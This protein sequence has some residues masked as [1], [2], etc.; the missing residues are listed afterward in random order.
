MLLRSYGAGAAGSS[1]SGEG[2][3]FPVQYKE[4]RLEDE[5][6]ESVAAGRGGRARKR[7][8]GSETPF[9]TFGGILGGGS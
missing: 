3:F 1:Q 8:S 7:S 2:K 6:R 5:R 4:C 9:L